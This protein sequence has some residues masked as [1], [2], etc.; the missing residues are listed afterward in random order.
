M[1]GLPVILD[2]K[3]S[4]CLCHRGT[5][6]LWTVE[7]ILESARVKRSAVR[8][9]ERAGR[10][11]ESTAFAVWCTRRALFPPPDEMLRGYRLPAHHV[12]LAHCCSE[13]VACLD[14][15]SLWALEGW[16]EASC[17]VTEGQVRKEALTGTDNGQWCFRV[18][19]LRFH[20]QLCHGRMAAQRA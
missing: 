12:G 9:R 4:T 20:Q 1:A 8:S 19:G 7:A 3:L 5:K 10:V 16:E 6:Q 2:G 18:D 13:E 15:D 11:G 14:L 17:V